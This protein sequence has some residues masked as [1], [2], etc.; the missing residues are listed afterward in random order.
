MWQLQH[1]EK[2]GRW[3]LRASNI[4]AAAG[5]KVEWWPITIK[6]STAEHQSPIAA[7]IKPKIWHTLTHIWLAAQISLQ[8]DSCCANHT[9]RKNK[10]EKKQVRRKRQRRKN[11][12]E[13]ER[14]KQ[15]LWIGSMSDSREQLACDVIFWLKL[16]ITQISLITAQ[17]LQTACL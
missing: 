10:K 4:K 5:K 3:N 6:N 7:I 2:E 15:K 12:I 13:N 17:H 16:H 1:R 11:R 14:R 8:L 9:V